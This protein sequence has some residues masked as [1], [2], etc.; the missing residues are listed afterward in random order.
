MAWRFVCRYH[1]N[2]FSICINF[3]ILVIFNIPQQ[4]K[5]KAKTCLTTW[6]STR[7]YL[8]HWYESQ[9]ELQSKSC[10]KS[11]GEN[12]MKV[13]GYL[14]KC[15]IADNERLKLLWENILCHFMEITFQN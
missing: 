12:K 13:P 15:L 10:V 14:R 4:N 1:T 11:N 8:K 3:C 5:T 9:N 2:I 6:H 7:K